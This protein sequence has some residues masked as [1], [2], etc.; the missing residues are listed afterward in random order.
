M[1]R[2]GLNDK[3]LACKC[4]RSFRGVA[5]AWAAKPWARTIPLTPLIFFENRGR[6]TLR[7]VESTSQD[8]FRVF[9]KFHI[10]TISLDGIPPS[11]LASAVRTRKSNNIT[12]CR[13][14]DS[15]RQVLT[16][17]YARARREVV[18]ALNGITEI[19]ALLSVFMTITG[20]RSSTPLCQNSFCQR[21]DGRPRLPVPEGE[22]V[23]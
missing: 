7:T 3:S 2:A 11:P 10:S 22:C 6:P 19:S 9:R 23:R 18:I 21:E 17:S 12:I 8:T 5:P 16:A 1:L 20:Q 14:L 4:T 15:C 13:G